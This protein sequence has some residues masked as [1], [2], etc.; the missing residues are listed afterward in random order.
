MCT[1]KSFLKNRMY[2]CIGKGHVAKFMVAE[3]HKMLI[4]HRN[5]DPFALYNIWKI[6]RT[7]LL[8]SVAFI[9]RTV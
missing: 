7:F 1:K 5:R 9:R 8:F 3:Q 2:A 6:F 4:N